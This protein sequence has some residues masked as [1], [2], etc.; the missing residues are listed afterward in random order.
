MTATCG[1]AAVSNQGTN[2]LRGAP[3][4]RSNSK[5][6]SAMLVM[7]MPATSAGALAPRSPPA[8]ASRTAATTVSQS[9]SGS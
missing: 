9:S 3:L 1:S 2:L 4:R 6:V 8:S 7:P 5:P